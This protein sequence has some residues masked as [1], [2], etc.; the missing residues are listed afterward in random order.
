MLGLNK[1]IFFYSG[2]KKAIAYISV[3][4]T[5]IQGAY[6]AIHAFLPFPQQ[7]LYSHRLHISH[8]RSQKENLTLS[9]VKALN[10]CVYMQS[11]LHGSPKLHECRKYIFELGLS[12]RTHGMQPNFYSNP[13]NIIVL[14]VS[15]DH[16]KYDWKVCKQWCWHQTHVACKW[17]N[18][19]KKTSFL[20]LVKFQNRFLTPLVVL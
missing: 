6:I 14:K 9:H 1:Q 3:T 4:N 10:V 11:T 2:S 5:D 8:I 7:R 12:L 13:E 16:A 18:P 19:T 20:G 17:V 15:R